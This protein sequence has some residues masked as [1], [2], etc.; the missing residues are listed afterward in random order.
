MWSNSPLILQ[1]HVFHRPRSGELCIW[2][3]LGHLITKKTSVLQLIL[4]EL[5]RFFT[6]RIC[7]HKFWQMAVQSC[8]SCCGCWFVWC[9]CLWWVN[10]LGGFKQYAKID[11]G[12]PVPA[13][14]ARHFLRIDSSPCHW[15]YLSKALWNLMSSARYWPFI[16]P[17]RAP[18]SWH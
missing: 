4:F 8:N 18:S 14:S 15:R 2:D 16:G 1:W 12:H 10:T 13:T 3:G 17:I 7:W 9:H 5:K 11:V 6:F